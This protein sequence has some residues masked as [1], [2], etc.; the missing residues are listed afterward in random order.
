MSIEAEDESPISKVTVEVITDAKKAMHDLSLASGEETDGTWEGTWA[1]DDSYETIYGMRL[2][3]T[4]PS[5]K[6]DQVFNFR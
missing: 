2:V 3:L 6:Y 1:I 5:V 4:S